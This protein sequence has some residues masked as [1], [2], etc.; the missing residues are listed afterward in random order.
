MTDLG[1]LG[2][3]SWAYR[4][5]SAGQ[6]AGYAAVHGEVTHAVLFAGSAAVKDLGTLG[7]PNTFAHGIN[8]SGQVVGGSIPAGGTALH[9]FL[10]T[11]AQG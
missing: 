4:I 1:G 8:G 9:A 2:G 10:Y 11:A 7:G 6:V 3:G 5:N